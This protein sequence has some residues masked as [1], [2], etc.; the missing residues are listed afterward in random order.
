MELVKLTYSFYR[1]LFLHACRPTRTSTQTPTATATLA[2]FFA[3]DE[4]ITF[5]PTLTTL[6]GQWPAP[7]VAPQPANQ[8]M[9]GL[10]AG[11]SFFPNAC[12]LGSITTALFGG[13]SKVYR[14]DLS[15]FSQGGTLVVQGCGSPFSATGQNSIVYLGSGCPSDPAT[16][17][18]LGAGSE[19]QQP[20]KACPLRPRLSERRLRTAVLGSFVSLYTATLLY[21]N[22]SM[23]P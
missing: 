2:N 17:G 15:A 4:S 11:G 8:A 5:M 12:P 6:T 13:P 7:G 21:N 18:C 9:L 19:C 1:L 14:I 3:C 22:D 20:T 23:S 16:F 10:E